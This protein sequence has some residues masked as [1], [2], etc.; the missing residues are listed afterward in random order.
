MGGAGHSSGSPVSERHAT[1]GISNRKRN[2]SLAGLDSSPGTV[3]SPEADASDDAHHEDRRKQP[4]KRAC[5]ECRQQKVSHHGP[6][7]VAIRTRLL[8]APADGEASFGA[9]SSK[10]PSNDAPAASDCA[11]NARSRAASSASASA[12]AMPRWRGRLQT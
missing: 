6:R 7:C 4:V 11:S 3:E 8:W 1:S 9:M 5:N 12:L 10:N 2:A